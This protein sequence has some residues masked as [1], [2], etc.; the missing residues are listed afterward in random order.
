MNPLNLSSDIS[1]LPFTNLTPAFVLDALASAGLHGDG[2]LLQLNSY[3]NRVFQVALEDG[4]FVVAK[5]YRPQRWSLAQILEEHEFSLE[6]AH[7]EIPV[8]APLALSMPAN[9]PMPLQLHGEHAT[10]GEVSSGEQNYRFSVCERRSGRSPDLENLETV[11]WLGR[12]LGR[13]H[14]AGQRQAFH[15]RDALTVKHWG[16]D[17]MTWLLKNQCIDPAAQSNWVAV[18]SQALEQIQTIFDRV[19]PAQLRLHGDC[20]VGNVL[21]SATGPHFVDLDDAVMGPAIQDL[22][23]LLPGE[24]SQLHTHPACQALIRGYR[25]FRELNLDELA[26]IEPLRTLRMIHHSVWL[27]RRWQDP[28]FP[29]AFPWFGQASYWCQQ[30]TVLRE[31]V[32]KMA[33]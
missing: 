17:S 21:W 11:E 14:R 12:F 7:E 2:R 4:R 24:E 5:F 20:H 8:V 31:Q 6:L 27:A 22:W 23:M 19:K 30:V 16:H 10:L 15:H 32:L 9:A 18:V 33:R 28:A 29:P 3:E 26:L 1:P 13:L 25:V